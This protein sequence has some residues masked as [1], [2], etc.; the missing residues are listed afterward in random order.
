MNQKRIETFSPDQLKA[1]ELIEVF[2]KKKIDRNDSKRGFDTRVLVIT[3]PAG[4]GKTTLIRYGL[5]D[6]ISVDLNNPVT[7][8]N[9]SGLN[10][11]TKLPKVVGLALAHKAKNNLKK[12]IPFVKT[13]ASYFGMKE[14][15]GDEG[16]ITFDIDPYTINAAWCKKPLKYA[17]HDE[18]SMY[19]INMIKMILEETHP[20]TKII[21]MGDSC[22]IPPINTEGD[23]DS[24]AFEIF[25][26]II[27]LTERHRQ[28][29][30]NPI[31]ALSDIFREE[32][33][34]SQNMERCLNALK[35]DHIVNGKGF[36]T[37]PYRDFLKQYKSVGP[38]FLEAKVIAYR[39]N[40]VNDYNNQIRSYLYPN[41][42]AMFIPGEIIY[43]NNTFYQEEET[44]I[45]PQDH[46]DEAIQNYNNANSK[47]YCYNSDEYKISEVD[48]F[49]VE[50]IKSYKIYFDKSFRP[51]IKVE[52][53][54][55]PFPHPSGMAKY[56]EVF[57]ARKSSALNEIDRKKKK[58]KWKYFYDFKNKFGDC[59]Y[60]YALTGHKAQGSGYTY[61]FID[62]N[63]I[64]TV[65]PI[66]NKRKLQ[67]IY[68]AMTRATDLAIFLKSNS[69]N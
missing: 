59:S 53:P 2:K 25:S 43:M 58:G 56:N 20:S 50:G 27:E 63:D 42:D 10:L 33:K 46:L 66:S 36:K 3:G 19:D 30:E 62:V 24:P 52:K 40:R 12:S 34:G 31:L 21:L 68:T 22:Q 41:A 65:G 28:S 14:N 15:H 16:Q 38:D 61:V 29:E 37:I 64:L 48:T 49:F 4:S 45:N 6:E 60:G 39:R 17:V 57:Y 55:I 67:A 5:E 35:A 11:F 7:E 44:P 51:D 23:L 1:L 8:E 47:Y 18:V 32:I 54:Y 13:F 9:S 69:N 26:N